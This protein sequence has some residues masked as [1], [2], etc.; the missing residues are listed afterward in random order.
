MGL[1][2]IKS[3]K[4]V[5]NELGCFH[6]ENVYQSALY[7]EFNEQNITVQTEIMVPII[8]KE[9]TIGFC[10]ADIVIYDNSVPI[11]ILELKS[12]STKLGNK[13]ISQLRKYLKYM[14][15]S[16]GYIIN[17]YNEL[18][19]IYVTIDDHKKIL[20]DNFL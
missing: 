10:R 11:H 13:E 20:Y 8:Y 9:Y 4:N 6:K 1:S 3:I 15:C 2:I 14:N 12:Q 19:I 5:Y 7:L 16:S 17:F 18:E